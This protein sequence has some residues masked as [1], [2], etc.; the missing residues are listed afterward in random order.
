MRTHHLLNYF[1][2]FGLIMS[3]SPYLQADQAIGQAQVE[4]LVEVPSAQDNE[5]I[6]P[7]EEAETIP[8]KEPEKQKFYKDKRLWAGA[9]VIGIVALGAGLFMKKQSNQIPSIPPDDNLVAQAFPE[10]VR[11]LVM[12]QLI[13]D[14]KSEMELAQQLRTIA[15]VDRMFND[16]TYQDRVQLAYWARSMELPVRIPTTMD[17][18]KEHLNTGVEYAKAGA[19]I[20]AP[21]VVEVAQS[22]HFWKFLLDMAFILLR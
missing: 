17:I 5:H 11:R 4:P 6:D 14:A 3:Q 2:I 21:V 7:T 1:I 8:A 22:P 20:A 16:I 12:L 19:E 15:Q 10:D 13:Q 18:V 9:A